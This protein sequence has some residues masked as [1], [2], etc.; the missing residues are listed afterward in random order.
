MKTHPILHAR[1][2]IPRSRFGCALLAFAL[3]MCASRPHTESPRVPD[4]SELTLDEKIGQMFAY[5]AHANFMTESSPAYQ[6]LMRQVRENKI[7]GVIWFASNVYE[8]AW[9]TRH[10][11]EAA[12]VPLL[13]SADLEGGIGMRFTD[14]TYWPRAMAL[15]A[16]GDPA[17]AEAQG[18]ITAIEAK[19]LGVNHILA[20][21]ADV[22]VDPDNPVINDRSFGEDPAAVGRFVAAFI[23]G[24]QSEGVLATAKH[25]PGH[26]DTHVDSHR[27]LP[28]LDVSRERLESVELRPFRAAIDAKVGSIMIGHLAL[29]QIDPTPA[30]PRRAEDAAE[31]NPYAAPGEV[32]RDG[33]VPATLSPVLIKDVLRR[34]LGYEGLIITD[35]M[36]MG[37]I[38]AHYDLGEAA[39]RAIEAGEDQILKYPGGDIPIQAVRDAVRSGRISEARID[40]SVRRILAAKRR[41]SFTPAANDELFRKLESPAHR[42]VVNEIAT[43]AITLVREEAGVLPLRRDARVVLVVVADLVEA[44]NPLATF[45]GYLQSRLG[46]RPVTFSLDPRSTREDARPILDAAGRADVV[47]LAFNV[48]ARTGTGTLAVPD[49][50]RWLT[51]ELPA[52]VKTIALA[53]GSPYLL[54]D[55]PTLRT[56]LAAYGFQPVLQTAAAK[57]LLGEASI[58]G[59]LPITIPGLHARGEG[60]QK[61]KESQTQQGA[62]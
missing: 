32:T 10:L 30:P 26:G 16:T 49:A 11:Q 29:P 38:L 51:T 35:A 43:K 46:T 21:V 36:D 59:K 7:G 12:R 47:V 4:L 9:L 39:I 56:Y 17:L 37:G 2:S 54:R 52:D 3:T 25:F 40:E 33:T 48:R 41:L 24:V 1:F 5:G 28:M 19:L 53:F 31:H 42:A 15:G 14:T 55:M 58:T 6:Q 61:V 18:R 34:D 22:N 57:A 50:A 45:A 62:Q 44:T 23:R 20:P 8:T 60:I 27:S 13:I